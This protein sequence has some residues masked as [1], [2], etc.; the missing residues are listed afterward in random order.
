[1]FITINGHL[2]S[3]KSAV[4]NYLKSA[5]GFDIFS[6][7]RIQREYA[8]KEGVSTLE[9]NEKSKSDYSLDHFIDDATVEYA[10]VHRNENVVFDSRLAWHFV[11]ESFKVHLLVAP[12]VAAARVFNNRK[13]EEEQYKSEQEALQKLIDRRKLEEDRYVSAYGLKMNDFS[14]YDMILD[15]TTLTESEVCDF[16]YREYQE[17]MAGNYT[18]KLF[19]SPRNIYPTEGIRNINM[20]VYEKYLQSI[21]ETHMSQVLSLI[22]ADD[23]LFILDGHHRVLAGNRSGVRIF[24]ATLVCDESEKMSNGLSPKE[25]I[26]ISLSDVYDW[27]DAA[28]FRFNYYPSIVRSGR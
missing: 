4:C 6:T 20:T 19:V 28:N 18:K 14:N 27:E 22:R 2:G 9:M 12:A 10:H 7:G 25:Y 23:C 11:P 21:G 17:F 5:H 15:T 1:M 13:T 3:G 16:V 8:T 26:T 24:P